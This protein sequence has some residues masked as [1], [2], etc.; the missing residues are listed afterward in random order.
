MSRRATLECTVEQTISVGDH[1]LYIAR[2][3]ALG[4][5]ERHAVPLLYYRRRY[6]RVERARELVPE[7]RPAE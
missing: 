6:L 5:D 3:D 7:G 1:D 4:T 2:V